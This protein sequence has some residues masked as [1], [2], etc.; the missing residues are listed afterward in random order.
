MLNHILVFERLPKF[1]LFWFF[2]SWLA[3]S[4]KPNVFKC[5]L[6]LSQSFNYES[7]TRIGVLWIFIFY[8]S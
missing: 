5:A 6:A 3:F 1:K 4:Q 7:S 8:N 2:I